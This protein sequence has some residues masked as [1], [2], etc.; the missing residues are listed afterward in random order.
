MVP[1]RTWDVV[2]PTGYKD[3]VSRAPCSTM[4]LSLSLIPTL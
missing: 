1:L 3:D 2:A 4:V